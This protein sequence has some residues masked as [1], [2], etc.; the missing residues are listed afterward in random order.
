MSTELDTEAATR[1]D[2]EPLTP[3]EAA[4]LWAESKMDEL[5]DA[6][7]E[8]QRNQIHAFVDWLETTTDTDDMRE[9]SARTVHRF[10]L[11]IKSDLAQ[12]T[13]SQ[14]IGIVRRFLRF[15]VSIDAVDPSV[16]ER[17]E[18]PKRDG[19]AR[20]EML[21]SEQAESAL[22]YLRKYA[23]ASRE[24]ALLALCWHTAIRTG[25][26]R[27]L[28]VSDVEEANNR[29]RV[30]HRPETD[31]P[32][33]NKDTAERYIALSEDVTEVLR[34]YIQQN[35]TAVTDDHGRKPLFA[36]ENGRAPVKTLRRWFQTMTRPCALGDC[37]HGRDPSDCDAARR[38]RDASDCPSSVS[39][40]PIRR[41]SITRHLREDIPEKVVSDR[42]NVSP[43]IL[44]RHYDRRSEDEKAE[45]RRQHL[46]NL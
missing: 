35:R 30:R 8:L 38:Q 43:D 25:T 1:T 9:V 28:D 20:T 16:P 10:K 21:D 15:C 17:V 4:R 29:L 44:D 2:L 37:P 41:G 32:L 24:H 3:E 22:S 5:A 40:H 19:E 11:D 18:L 23:Y 6:T 34:D 45:Q 31:T 39:G 12:S 27:A 46:D 33:K 14:R 26:L 42:C 36:T 7:L 13:L